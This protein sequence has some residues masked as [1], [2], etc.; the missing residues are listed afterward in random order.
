MQRFTANETEAIVGLAGGPVIVA[1]LILLLLPVLVLIKGMYGQE[2]IPDTVV[3]CRVQE[4]PIIVIKSADSFLITGAK[5]EWYYISD[6]SGNN[7]VKFRS[8]AS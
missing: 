2:N 5:E 8:P 7:I 6:F 4:D 1:C 3:S